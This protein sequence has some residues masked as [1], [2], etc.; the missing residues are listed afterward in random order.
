MKRL[1]GNII[2]INESIGMEWAK[3]SVWL[4]FIGS[5]EPKTTVRKLCTIWGKNVSF[6]YVYF[7]QIK[8]LRERV[9]V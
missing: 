4:I 3:V 1:L 5:L 9:R 2:E 6:Y 7:N 8:P